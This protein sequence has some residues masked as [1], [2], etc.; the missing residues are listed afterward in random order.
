MP[1][2]PGAAAVTILVNLRA[3]HGLQQHAHPSLYGAVSQSFD[4]INGGSLR[5]VREKPL[6]THKKGQGI[7]E[8][9]KPKL[10]SPCFRDCSRSFL[11]GIAAFCCGGS[12]NFR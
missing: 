2:H 4:R 6:S 5:R 10:N 11:A 7:H 1:T 3:S 12:R 9:D 8:L